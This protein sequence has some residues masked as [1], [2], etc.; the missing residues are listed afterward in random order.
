LLNDL[1][2]PIQLNDPKKAASVK[3]FC[4]YPA[5]LEL[6]SHLFNAFCMVAVTGN[7]DILIGIN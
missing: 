3:G 7:V 1:L 6:Q 5:G 4:G 2:D